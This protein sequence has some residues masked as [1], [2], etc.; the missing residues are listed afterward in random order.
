[1]KVRAACSSSVVSAEANEPL[2]EVA[3]RMGFDE[4]GSVVVFEHGQFVGIITERDIVRAMA[5]GADPD[6]TAA[7]DYM[8]EDPVI[9]DIDDDLERAIE[10]MVAMGVRHLPVMAGGHVV[11]ML[12]ARDLLNPRTWNLRRSSE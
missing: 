10:E 2:L 4:V 3:S 5:D 1:M 11:G 7:R 12:S 8:T 6:E 9:V